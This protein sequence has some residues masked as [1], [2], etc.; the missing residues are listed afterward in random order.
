MRLISFIKINCII[1]CE[2]AL[3]VRVNKHLNNKQNL[4]Y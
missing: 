2:N 1:E 3:M 4:A